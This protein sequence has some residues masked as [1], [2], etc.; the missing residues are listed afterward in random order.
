MSKIEIGDIITAYHAGYHRVMAIGAK[1][2]GASNKMIT[3]E[4]V[5]DKT[6]KKAG[7]RLQHCD[8]SYCVKLTPAIANDIIAKEMLVV[9]TLSVNLKE[10]LGIV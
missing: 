5:L 9:H 8:S 10:L 7:V 1:G 6:G 3:Y 4:R 2:V